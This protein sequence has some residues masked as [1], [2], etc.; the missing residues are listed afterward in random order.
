MHSFLSSNDY[1]HY[2]LP[3]GGTIKEVRLIQSGNPGGGKLWW[4]AERKR[5]AFDPSSLGWQMLETRGCVIVDTGDYGVVALLP[6]GMVTIGSV[7]FEEHIKPGAQVKKGDL[8]GHFA[9]GGS[10]FVMIF[11][12]KVNFT[13]DAPKQEG[14]HAYQHLLMGERLGHLS[15]K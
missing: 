11:Q 3:V 7:N 1:H 12:D 14:R 5:Y 15:L 8:L 6:V 4:D 9:F 13:L 10:D 2:H